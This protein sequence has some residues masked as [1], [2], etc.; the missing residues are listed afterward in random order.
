M[1]KTLIPLY[2]AYNDWSGEFY[3]IFSFSG[4]AC[5]CFSGDLSDKNLPSYRIH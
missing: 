1:Q 3:V 5:T 2:D 4:W